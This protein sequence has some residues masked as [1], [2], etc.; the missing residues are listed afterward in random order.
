MIYHF[1]R[2]IDG[3]L[4][5][6]GASITG[7]SSEREAMEIAHAIFAVDAESGEMERTEFVL[8]REED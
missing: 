3:R 1:D 4:M 5:A 6:E 2:Y 7:A 8:Q